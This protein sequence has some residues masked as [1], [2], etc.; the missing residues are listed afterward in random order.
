MA[1]F[2]DLDPYQH[3]AL[4]IQV[5]RVLCWR[6]RRECPFD[7]ATQSDEGDWPDEERSDLRGYWLAL[8]A[9]IMR[10]VDPASYG[11][12]G[13]LLDM[14]GHRGAFKH[15]AWTY[16]PEERKARRRSKKNRIATVAANLAYRGILSEEPLEASER[17]SLPDG[18]PQ[19]Q[20]SADQV[21]GFLNSRKDSPK[22]TP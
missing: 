19:T 2:S 16:S 14:A 1:D 21:L 20:F 5:H 13:Q 10:R 17:Q 12:I 4:T 8:T 6:P 7:R 3:I 18:P 11:L 22:P 15:P 9:G